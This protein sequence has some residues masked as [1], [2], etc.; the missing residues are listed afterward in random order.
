M[1]ITLN[2]DQAEVPDGTSL[3]GLLAGSGRDGRRR[4]IAIAVNGSV[5]PRGLWIEQQVAEGDIVELLT[6]TQG[7]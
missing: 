1:I 3:E 6:A 7:G 4:G 2:G 5:V